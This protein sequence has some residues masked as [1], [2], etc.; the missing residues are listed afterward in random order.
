MT[1]IVELI[2]GVVAK[3]NTAVLPKL[4]AYQSTIIGVNYLYGHPVEIANTLVEWS[5]GNDNKKYPLIALLQDFPETMGT[6]GIDADVTLRVLIANRTQNTYKAAKR[7]EVNFKPI[8]Y[9]VYEEFI[10]QLKRSG[11]TIGYNNPHTKID[12]LYWGTDTFFGNG[13]ANQLND[14]AD[15][16]EIQNLKLII[17]ENL[18]C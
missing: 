10:K 8:L 16:I 17:N 15:C 12:R 1:P 14:Y 2:G 7:Y 13:A 4:Q 5:K 9:P 18:N 6:V 11:F 3:V